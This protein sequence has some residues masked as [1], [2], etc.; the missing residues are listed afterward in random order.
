M[1][2][3]YRVAA[4]KRIVLTRPSGSVATTF[5][6]FTCNGSSGFSARSHNCAAVICNR[7]DPICAVCGVVRVLYKRIA[8]PSPCRAGLTCSVKT[9]AAGFWDSGEAQQ[10]IRLS[11]AR[12]LRR[13]THMLQQWL[14]IGRLQAGTVG[15]CGVKVTAV[16]VYPVARVHAAR[17]LRAEVGFPNRCW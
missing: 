4:D 5:P 16:R 2:C 11:E 13:L 17:L 14:V 8:I 15:M 7:P 12:A 9:A 3:A 1:L 6:S 10:R